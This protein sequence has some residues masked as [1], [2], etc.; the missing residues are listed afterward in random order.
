MDFLKKLEIM[1]LLFTL[2]GLYM[3]SEK[4]AAGFLIFDISLFCQFIIFWTQKNRFL[5][6]Q[7]V[8]LMVYNSYIFFKWTGGI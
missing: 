6:F 5:M 7:M 8:V 2:V 4:M 1:S 3:I